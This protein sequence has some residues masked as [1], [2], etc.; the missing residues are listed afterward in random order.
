MRGR[1]L[2]HDSD[3]DAVH[4]RRPEAKGGRATAQSS[5]RRGA[6]AAGGGLALPDWPH[7]YDT[8]RGEA[9]RRLVAAT[10]PSKSAPLHRP[11]KTSCRMRARGRAG[12]GRRRSGRCMRGR[13]AGGTRARTAIAHHRTRA[14]DGNGVRRRRRRHPEYLLGLCKARAS[15]AAASHR[16]A[17]RTQ[18]LRRVCDA[19][20]AIQA[21]L[22]LRP[23]SELHCSWL[24]EAQ[25]CTPPQPRAKQR[26]RR[27]FQLT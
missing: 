3:R 13:P 19:A 14:R 25:P 27:L 23:H 22:C 10:A 16:R 6:A 12:C 8:R 26:E 2:A 9:T 17:A 1:H 7:H 21:L 15:C 4:M 18:A 11:A 5:E 20:G 24:A